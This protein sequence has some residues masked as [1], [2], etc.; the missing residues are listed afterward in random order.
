MTRKPAIRTAAR[1]T[2]A[3]VLCAFVFFLS[4][5]AVSPTLHKWLHND[6]DSPGHECV[7]TLFASGHVAPATMAPALAVMGALFG[8][9]LLL[10]QTF[11][12]AS[13]DYRFSTSR[14]PP[15]GSS[16]L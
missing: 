11:T 15:R 2:T 3:V 6:S 9:V 8:G 10:A 16:V 14:S 7:V 4:V 1:Q 12:P 5:V 13:A